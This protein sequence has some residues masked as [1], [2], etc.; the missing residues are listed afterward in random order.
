MLVT[1]TD[2]VCVTTKT[3][4]ESEEK[5]W[6]SETVTKFL[7]KYQEY[8]EAFEKT[9][10]KKKL[11]NRFANEFNEENGKKF[12]V[13]QLENK[14]KSLKRQY[15]NVRNHNS[16]SGNN[17]RNWEHYNLMD[18]IM[19]KKPEINAPATCSSVSGLSVLEESS[20][21]EKEGDTE[22]SFEG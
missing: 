16:K 13:L 3:V 15:K 9:K 20:E 8:N 18:D 10:Y 5:L 4:E 22:S 17:R 21:T 12:T 11:W 2:Q 19:H 14:L 7:V 6:P 1:T